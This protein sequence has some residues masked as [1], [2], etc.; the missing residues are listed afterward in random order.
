MDRRQGRVLREDGHGLPALVR[1]VGRAIHV[2]TMQPTCESSLCSPSNP[3]PIRQGGVYFRMVF[4]RT[5]PYLRH[6]QPPLLRPP[7]DS[8]LPQGRLILPQAGPLHSIPQVLRYCHRCPIPSRGTHVGGAVLDVG[9]M[10]AF[11]ALD[12]RLRAELSRILVLG[13]ACCDSGC[14]LLTVTG[15]STSLRQ[16][17]DHVRRYGLVTVNTSCGCQGRR[18]SETWCSDVVIFKTVAAASEAPSTCTLEST[19]GSRGTEMGALQPGGR[20]AEKYS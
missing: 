10:A 2:T 5:Y 18:K 13:V 12:H 11:S 14:S 3:I 6:L 4:C 1:H 15:P 7:P 9:E 16:G 19:N 20:T 8:P 17:C